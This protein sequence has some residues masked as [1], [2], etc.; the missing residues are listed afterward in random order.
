[1]RDFKRLTVWRK[2]HEFTLNVYSSTSRFPSA[3]LYG[4]TSQLRRAASSI[5]ANIAEGCGRDSDAELARFLRIAMGSG[6]ELEYFL[7]LSRDLKYVQ[8]DEYANLLGELQE[9]KRMLAGLL[10][11]LRSDRMGLGA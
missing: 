6:N 11:R 5:P 10:S 8:L 4:L 2:S 1:M 3:E 9:V 7:L